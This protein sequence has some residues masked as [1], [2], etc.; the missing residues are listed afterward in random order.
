M[1]E[2]VLNKDR[3]VSRVY[4][5]TGEA[6]KQHYIRHGLGML[7]QDVFISECEG[8]CLVKVISKDNFRA[9]VQFDTPQ[10]MVTVK[11][12]V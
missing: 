1:G 12:E 5:F 10:T 4:L 3:T 7:P 6:G 11:F 9:L 2:P 8:F